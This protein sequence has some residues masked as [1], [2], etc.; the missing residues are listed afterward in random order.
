VMADCLVRRMLKRTDP[1]CHSLMT[2]PA[3][4]LSLVLPP[5]PSLS[6]PPSAARKLFVCLRTSVSVCR[7]GYREPVSELAR[8]QVDKLQARD[9]DGYGASVGPFG[10]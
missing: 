4:S 10:F 5:A 2:I 8:A 7:C 6:L 3:L 1:P 9:G